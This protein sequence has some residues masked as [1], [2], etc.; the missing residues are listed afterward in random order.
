MYKYILK[1]LMMLI[2]VVVGI[3]FLVFFILKLTPG[4]PVRLI[5]GDMATEEAKAQLRSDLGL[6][7]PLLVQYAN[8]MLRMVGGDLGRSYTTRRDVASEI[9]SRFSVTFKL[10]I[11]SMLIS[12]IIAIP[13]GIVSATKQY[14]LM[15]NASMVACLIGV[16]IPNFWLGLML[17]LLF[18]VHL[19]LLPSVG[20]DSWRNFILPSITLGVGGAANIARMMRSSML[21]VIRQDYIRT[22]RAKGVKK[23]KIIRKHALRN[24]MMPVITII[25]LQFGLYLGGAVLTETVFSM[26]GTGRLLLDGIRAKDTPTVLGCVTVFALCY[27]LVNLLVDLIY[28]FLDPRIRAEYS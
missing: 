24:A 8:F 11:F 4:D 20:S 6:D 22:A 15:D 25:G 19:G 18:S 16:S 1:R 7:K 9:R 26:S 5:L 17:L 28:G 23:G 2:P 12:A 3:T 10:A 13:V 27:S 14:S 21:E